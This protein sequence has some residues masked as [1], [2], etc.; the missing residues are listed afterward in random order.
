MKDIGWTQVS[1][2]FLLLINLCLRTHLIKMIH[3]TKNQIENLKKEINGFQIVLNESNQWIDKCLKY[4]DFERA[5][6]KVKNARRLIRKVS[7][8]IDSKPVFALFGA[9]QVGKSY[10]I[11]NI[12]SI[13]GHPLMIDAGELGYDFLKDI[14]PPGTGAES[15]GV[16][17]R[18]SIEK[19]FI[20]DAF[21]VEIKLLNVKDLIII[22][23]DSYFSDLKKLI[24]YPSKEA[25][26]NH[27]DEILKLYSPKTTMHN[28]LIEED[29]LDIKEY[30]ENNFN[31]F[32]G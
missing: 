3:Y 24:D 11:K 18:F 25:F 9:S 4:E 15:T 6:F 12:L 14:N 8:S 1:F 20:N 26:Q 2:N 31:K 19:S 16:V 27:A 7:Q 13:D 5:D 23:C 32:Y 17:T 22:F 30:F 28:I 29:I 10:L 21:P